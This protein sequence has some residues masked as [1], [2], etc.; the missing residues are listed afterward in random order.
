MPARTRRRLELLQ[1]SDPL[2]RYATSLN[3]DVN[4]SSLMVHHALSGAFA[5]LD[6]RPS[7]GLEA[8][9]RRDID[10]NCALAM[11]PMS[12]SRAGPSHAS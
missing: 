11:P 9:L 1:L 8:S 3:P 10:R 6:M 7:L 2:R 4:A 12:T 5:E